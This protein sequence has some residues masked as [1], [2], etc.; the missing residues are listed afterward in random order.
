MDNEVL[1]AYSKAGMTMT[2]T[3][4]CIKVYVDEGG[5]A[6]CKLG[7]FVQEFDLLADEV[8]LMDLDDI[9]SIFR[10]YVLTN[11]KNPYATKRYYIDAIKLAYISVYSDGN[12]VF[13]PA[14]LYYQSTDS[15]NQFETHHVFLAVSAVD[16]TVYVPCEPDYMRLVF[17]TDFQQLSW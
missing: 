17:P 14:Y 15:S 12:T 10:E 1:Y 2:T 9:D 13:L 5:V 11:Y 8:E 4:K 16:G 7:D 3:Q 6:F